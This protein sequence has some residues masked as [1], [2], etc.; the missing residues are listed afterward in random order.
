MALQAT[1]YKVELN[2]TDLD[3][4]VYENTRFTVARHPS[5]TEERLAAR[6]IAHALWSDEQLA[7][8]RGLSDVD[9][10]ALWIRSLDGRVLHWIEVGQPDADRLVWC[11]RRAERVSLLAYGNTRVWQ[12]KVL[13][14]VRA[15]KNLSVAALDQDALSALSDGLPRS[16]QWSVMI[17]DGSLFV[18][19][20]RGQHEIPLQ[21]L[22][23]ER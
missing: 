9:E 3:R 1:P 4:G 7:F 17:S 19:D 5:E 16:V 11:S 14:S 12:S 23:G 20:E 10:P 15:V 22:K 21:W 2:L 8:G 13:D 18:T 6:L